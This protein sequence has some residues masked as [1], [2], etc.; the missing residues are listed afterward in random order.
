MKQ[1]HLAFDT[2]QLLLA[3]QLFVE[4]AHTCRADSRGCKRLADLCLALIFGGTASAALCL[5]TSNIRIPL[6]FV[7]SN[8][9]FSS[10]SS[11]LGR[12][13]IDIYKSSVRLGQITR[14]ISLTSVRLDFRKPLIF[15]LLVLTLPAPTVN[16]VLLIIVPDTLVLLGMRDTLL[17]GEFFPFGQ[18]FRFR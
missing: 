16:P 2:L 6:L 17:L 1:P 10:I 12:I 5:C 4:L 15:Q 13:M 9:C 7:L 14:E 11:N 8:P 3:V 18:W